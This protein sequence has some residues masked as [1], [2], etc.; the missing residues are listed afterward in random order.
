[1]TVIPWKSQEGPARFRLIAGPAGPD[2][3][4]TDDVRGS[5]LI[6]WQLSVSV[7]MPMKSAHRFG[8]YRRLQ[9]LKSCGLRYS[10]TGLLPW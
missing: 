10:C 5:V 1:M 7:S 3:T 8:P 6:A 9:Q 2:R 4:A